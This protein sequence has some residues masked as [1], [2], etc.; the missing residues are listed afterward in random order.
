MK[1]I[2]I[3]LDEETLKNVNDTSKL[4]GLTRSAFIRMVLTRYNYAEHLV[5]N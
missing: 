4:L 1:A 2:L 3:S 5:R